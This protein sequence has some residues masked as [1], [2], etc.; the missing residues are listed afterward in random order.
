MNY[1]NLKL[2]C[3]EIDRM[4]NEEMEIFTE[5]YPQTAS[6]YYSPVDIFDYCLMLSHTYGDNEIVVHPTSIRIMFSHSSD[7]REEFLDI[8]FNHHKDTREEKDFTNFTSIIHMLTDYNIDLEKEL[9]LYMEQIDRLKNEPQ[10][11]KDMMSNLGVPENIFDITLDIP[12]VNKQLLKSI[13]EKK[14]LMDLEKLNENIDFSLEEKNLIK[15]LSSFNYSFKLNLD[16][17]EK[18][19]YEKFSEEL[20]KSF[21]YY[22]NKNRLLEYQLKNK[23]FL[24]T[25][26]EMSL[27]NIVS[28]K[29]INK[30]RVKI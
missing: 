11:F 18:E 14:Q 29:S 7:N 10:K 22:D 17:T 6:L 13:C 20:F 19:K 1:K 9:N 5:N 28:D 3:L 23:M 15:D 8:D 4:V 12:N 27:M 21:T 30:K 25:I 16:V 24:E 2:K 26:R